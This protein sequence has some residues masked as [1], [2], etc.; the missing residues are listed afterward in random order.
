MLSLLRGEN[1]RDMIVQIADR[2]GQ[3]KSLLTQLD[4]AIGDGDHGITMEAGL[5]KAKDTVLGLAHVENAYEVFEQAGKAMLMSMGGASGVIFGS[6]FMGGAKGAAPKAALTAEDFAEMM[7]RS[8]SVIRERGKARP[9]DK[10]MVDA[11]EP[12][13]EAMRTHAGEGYAAMLCAGEAAAVEG[14][15]KTKAYQAKFG[16]AKSLME[17]A[18]GH[19]DAGAVST[20]IILSAMREYAEQ[21]EA[22]NQVQLL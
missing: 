22:A 1:A 6:L 19:P 15:E 18:V 4:S 5:K 3:S 9:G 11:L 16:R 7:G 12:A 14:A 10:T 17:R 21:A 2:I 20:G 13:V 8:L